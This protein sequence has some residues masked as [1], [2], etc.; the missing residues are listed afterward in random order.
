M[1]GRVSEHLWNLDLLSPFQKSQA[2]RE[3]RDR[4][5]GSRHAGLQFGP[6]RGSAPLRSPGITSESS[7]PWASRFVHRRADV[8]CRVVIRP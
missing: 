3:G 5:R 8:A 4:P 7:R 6:K 1:T 2:Q